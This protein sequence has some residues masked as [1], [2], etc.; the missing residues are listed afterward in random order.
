MRRTFW[1]LLLVGFLVVPAVGQCPGGGCP[2]GSCPSVPSGGTRLEVRQNTAVNRP[3]PA[4]RY[5]SARA[6]R[7]AVV[8]VYCFETASRRSIGSGVL[9][10]LGRQVAIL[11]ARH[12]VKDAQ[13][14]LVQFHT[15]KRFP[16]RVLRADATWD[17]AVLEVSERPEGI[18]PAQM[19]WGEEAMLHRGDR[20]ESCGYGPDGRLAVNSG[21]FLGYRRSTARRQG[22][23][24]WMVLSGHAR[25]G[26]SGGPIFNQAGHVVG[27]LWGTDGSEVVGVQAG[28]V[29]VVLREALPRAY[30]QKQ[31]VERTPT[32]PMAEPLAPIRRL[33]P[34]SDS[35]SP[36]SMLAA[37]APPLLPW[38][39]EAEKRDDAQRA[40]IDRLIELERLRQADREASA[41]G[42]PVVETRPVVAPKEETPASATSPLLAGLCVLGGAGLGFVIY[43]A[44]EKGN[45][46]G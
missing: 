25:S 22:P 42:G 45:A 21:L 19:A 8:R 24:D 40:A 27:V 17:C 38:R 41:H 36:A 15:G 1:G 44:N 34:P 46:H 35:G 23:D 26:D 13:K 2:G 12:V 3:T 6:H 11:T 31:I 10:R 9:V 33:P 30:Q 39:G 5:E 20:L 18:E 4:W 32:R 14:I 28:R 16:A 37:G 7:A 43:F 29:H